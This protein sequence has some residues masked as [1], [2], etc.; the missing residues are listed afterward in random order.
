MT[1]T[2]RR[3]LTGAGILLGLGVAFLAEEHIRGA[4]EL[5]AWQRAMRV[6]GEKLT[7]AELT[8]KL[9]NVAGMVVGSDEAAS[10]FG[11]ATA[12]Q[13]Y[14]TAMH[15]VVPG[16]ARV[17][18]KQT[19]WLT[20]RLTKPY[21]VMTN[22]W[23]EPGMAG[24]FKL[25]RETLP[26]LRSDLTNH[27]FVVRLD[28]DLGFD[29]PLPHLAREKSA[30][31][32]LCAD[33]VL[34]LHEHRLD[35]AMA[36]L[37][38]GTALVDQLRQEHLLIGQLV[39]IADAAIL[40]GAVWEALQADGWSDAQLAAIQTGWESPRFLAGMVQAYE[41]ERA[42]TCTYY[43]SDRYSNRKLLETIV[44]VQPINSVFS[45]GGNGTTDGFLS[46]LLN[47]FADGTQKLRMTLHLVLWRIAWADQDQLF[48][49]QTMQ[50]LIVDG[51]SAVKKRTVSSSLLPNQ[52]ADDEL[53][54]G[55]PA[56]TSRSGYDRLRYLLSLTAADPSV[57]QKSA[58]RA[59]RE[60]TQSE[61][62]LAAIAI[63]R[64]QLRQGRLPETL[65]ALVP[66]F[67]REVPRDWFNGQPLHYRPNADG[68][69]LLYSVGEDGKDD[70]GNPRS[71]ISVALPS[72]Y[73]GR[74]LVWP[75]PATPAEVQAAEQREFKRTHR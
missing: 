13:Y 17:A 63:K 56:R 64:Y 4:I 22:D 11:R 27:A 15:L 20:E 16:R 8:P 38:A 58:D 29:V 7:V 74:D 25:L 50:K 36:D 66:E 52:S 57:F 14:P 46:G 18:W 68:T 28:Y 44:S 37:V 65:A 70:G 40:Q 26:A 12:P 19:N 9:T 30:V 67:L 43:D 3:F 1:R 47:A 33:T 62:I 42:I 71:R 24:A 32:A 31:Q 41:M 39:R 49:C 5:H 35:D 61:M 34:A 54:F 48:Y 53:P 60:E 69:F 75:M 73:N 59:V 2:T 6:K 45:G 23:S 10:L 51:R 55:T 72:F 21:G